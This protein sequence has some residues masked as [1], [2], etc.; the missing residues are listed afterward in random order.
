MFFHLKHFL[1]KSYEFLEMFILRYFVFNC[2]WLCSIYSLLH[3]S[4]KLVVWKYESQNVSVYWFYFSLLS[5][6]WFFVVT[7]A[8]VINGIAVKWTR[9]LKILYWWWKN[10]NNIWWLKS[11]LP[12]NSVVVQLGCH[13]STAGGT[14]LISRLGL[15]GKLRSCTPC[16][17]ARKKFCSS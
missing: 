17:V 5:C 4:F 15:V 6:L 3:Y 16:D 10:V 14:D 9:L 7:N 2:Y 12:G 11:F 13:A 8:P 1:F